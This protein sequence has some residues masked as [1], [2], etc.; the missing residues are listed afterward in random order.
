MSSRALRKLER[1]KLQELGEASNSLEEEETPVPTSK[2]KFNAFA[3]LN[4]GESSEESD[5]EGESKTDTVTQTPEEK[6]DEVQERPTVHHDE[7]TDKKKSKTR[8]K[9]KGKNQTKKNKDYDSDEELDRILEEAKKANEAA[10]KHTTTKS[11]TEEIEDDLDSFDI[12]EEYDL[13]DI[14]VD[15][16]DSNFKYFTSKRLKASLPLLSIK[17]SKK[18]DPDQEFRNLFGN[19]SLEAIDDAN[20][21]SSLAISPEVLAQFKRLARLTR[22]WSGKDRRSVPGTT[23]KLLMSKIRDDWLPTAQKPLNMEEIS[24][25]DIIRYVDYKEDD[26]SPDELELKMKNELKLGIKYFRFNK[27]ITPQETAANTK[28]YASVVLTPDPES[29]IHMLQVYPYHAETLLQVAMILLRQGNEKS[30]SNSLVERALFIFDRSFSKSFHEL[31]QEG[32]S[33]LIRLPY[34]SFMNRQ[35]HLCLFRY[36][37]GLGERRLFSTALAY[38]KFLLSL[39]PTEDPLGVRYFIDFYAIMSEEF[40]YLTQLAKSPLCTTYKRWY[41]PGIAYSTVLAYLYLNDTE[42]AK[43]EL[44][45]AFERHPL[46]AIKLYES[47]GLGSIP[48]SDIKPSV[49]EEVMCETYM[50]RAGAMWTEQNHR[51]FLSDE[52]SAIFKEKQ[53]SEGS[54]SIASSFMSFFTKDN[55]KS[56]DIPL[57]LIRF[58]IVSGENKILGKLPEKVWS[59]LHMFEY[60]VLPPRDSRVAYNEFTGILGD[61]DTVIDAM[62]NYVNHNLL[63]NLVQEAATNDEFLDFAQEE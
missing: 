56:S 19:L 25:G 23:R 34:E 60:D 31:L 16:F 4:D 20:S 41:T 22:G 29:L 46:T 39:N 51:Q 48:P 54:S 12:E 57:N 49:E 6:T 45:L 7:E 36:I 61:Q 26:L 13:H 59:M 8:S 37:V 50:V 1:K 58:A 11:E 30:T 14:P 15:D 9:K 3:L 52:L 53:K 5:S 17:S 55:Q 43:R 21:T 10:A 2:P 63:G 62:I 40:K 18:L 28:F 32:K 38:C 33:E 42:N 44:R 24:R 47:I 35:F 27:I